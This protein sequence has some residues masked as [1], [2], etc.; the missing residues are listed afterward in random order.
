MD[1]KAIES[2]KEV[3][4]IDSKSAKWIASDAIRELSSEIIQ[5]RLKKLGK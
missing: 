4:K 1:R 5:E 3:Q 2:A